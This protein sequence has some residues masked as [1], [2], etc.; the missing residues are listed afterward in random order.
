[1]TVTKEYPAGKRGLAPVH[2]GRIWRGIIVEGLEIN[3][4]EAANRMGV[5]RRQLHRILSGE[6]YRHV[7]NAAGGAHGISLT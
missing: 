1:M 5:S 6:T 7:G 4:S 3:I 2:P